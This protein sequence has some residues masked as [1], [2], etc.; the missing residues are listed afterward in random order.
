MLWFLM[1]INLQNH[2]KTTINRHK[3]TNKRDLQVAS[4]SDQT[5]LDRIASDP[6]L[7]DRIILDLTL[8]VLTTT[9]LTLLDLVVNNR[10]GTIPIISANNN[11]KDLSRVF[12]PDDDRYILAFSAAFKDTVLENVRNI[13]AWNHQTSTVLSV[14]ELTKA[15]ASQDDDLKHQDRPLK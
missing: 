12:P 5:H 1:T 3:I 15:N 4:I 11:R 9:D 8:L 10:I 6:T 2:S 13:Q 7:L 14:E